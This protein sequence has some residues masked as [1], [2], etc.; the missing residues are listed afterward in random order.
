MSFEK[1]DLSCQVKC[2][3]RQMGR[4]EVLVW[5]E[6]K[7]ETYIEGVWNIKDLYFYC[8]FCMLNVVIMAK[9]LK[10]AETPT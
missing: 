10:S 1:W 7:Q 9:R 3:G 4:E 6:F 2:V 8:I 5:V